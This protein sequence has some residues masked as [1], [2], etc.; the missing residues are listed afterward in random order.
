MLSSSFPKRKEDHMPQT[1]TKP[2]A[3]SG[4]SPARRAAQSAAIRSWS[5]W[6]NS[7]GPRTRAG[8]ARS[9]RN[10]CK[11]GPRHALHNAL[12]SMLAHQRRLHDM[13]LRHKQKNPSNELLNDPALRT[14]NRAIRDSLT[15]LQ[16]IIMKTFCTPKPPDV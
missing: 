16:P 12:L 13:A 4:W 9:S 5:P 7:T 1:A 14:Y 10:A 8:K 15:L 3:S 2:R 11:H 6:A